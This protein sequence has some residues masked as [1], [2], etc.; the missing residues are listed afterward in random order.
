M[1]AIS[2]PNIKHVAFADDLTGGGTIKRLRLWWDSVLAVDQSLGYYANP[3][4]SCLIVRSKYLN[5]I[6][7]GPFGG[8]SV[9]GGG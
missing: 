2:S 9:P 8:S 6:N 1:S 5:P 7:T 4:K 3:K